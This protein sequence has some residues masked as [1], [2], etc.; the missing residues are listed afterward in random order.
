MCGCERKKSHC[1]CNNL[2]VPIDTTPID[3]YLTR[4]ERILFTGNY[5]KSTLQLYPDVSKRMESVEIDFPTLGAKG[6]TYIQFS[7]MT[8]KAQTTTF[9]DL[10]F[11]IALYNNNLIT[12]EK[13]GQISIINIQRDEQA[14]CTLLR[15]GPIVKVFDINSKSGYFK[16]VSK[17][18]LDLRQPI[19]VFYFIGKY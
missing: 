11:D 1:G 14:D 15:S 5:D 18:I 6:F 9:V 19:R 10:A 13:I 12:G 8:D 2:P 7:C 17:V 16:D 3:S 4:C